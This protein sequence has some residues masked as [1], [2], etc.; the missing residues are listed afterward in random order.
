MAASILVGVLQTV[1]V[2]LDISLMPLLPLKLSELGALLPYVLMIFV[3]LFKPT[4]L[5][6]RREN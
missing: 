2:S 1:T 3:L 6:G 5:M 4:G